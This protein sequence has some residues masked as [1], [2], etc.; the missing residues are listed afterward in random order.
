MPGAG[1][2]VNVDK[3][4]TETRNQKPVMK[5]INPKSK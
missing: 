2:R 5:R 4:Q 3:E 1:Y